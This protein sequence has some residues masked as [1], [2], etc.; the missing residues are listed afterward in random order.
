ME[1]IVLINADIC[2]WLLENADAPIRYRISRE[3]QNIKSDEAGKDLLENPMVKLWLKNLKPDTPPQHLSMVHGSFDYNL[4][5]AMSKAVQLGLHGGLEPLMDAADFYLDYLKYVAARSPRSFEFFESNMIANFFCLAGIKD[6]TALDVMLK[7]L[8]EIYRFMSLKDYD[9]YTGPEERSRLKGI[10]KN[11]NDS[12]YFIKKDLTDE[13]GICYPLIHDI[14]GLHKLYSLRIPE[15]DMKINTIIEN[16][17]TDD[18]HSK[19]A[20]RYGILIA[21]DKHYFS[22]GWDPKYPGWFDV[23]KYM[24]TDNVPKLLFFAQYI[25]KY[26]AALKTAWF[27]K[28]LGVLETYKTDNDTYLFP[29]EW[30]K[31]SPGYAVLGSHLSFG[32]NRRKKNWREIESTF[33]MLLLKQNI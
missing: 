26:P 21:G 12:I 28:L 3:F 33:Y 19:I 2:Q 13:Y 24:E 4:E 9:I 8:D 14:V 15:V 20:D 22:M 5:N 7:R 18:F 6:E 25:T 32:E 11:W 23:S 17:S 29:A 31:E 30:L 16:I 1:V 10:P 27:G